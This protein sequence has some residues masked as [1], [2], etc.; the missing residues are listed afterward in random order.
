[1]AVC[2]PLVGRGGVPI[3]VR[4]RCFKLAAYSRAVLLTAPSGLSTKAFTASPR[5]KSLNRHCAEESVRLCPTFRVPWELASTAA[6]YIRSEFTLSND[7]N[8]SGGMTARCEG[9]VT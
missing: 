3:G 1:M 8:L 7:A 4:H 2:E 6:L 9:D 5:N